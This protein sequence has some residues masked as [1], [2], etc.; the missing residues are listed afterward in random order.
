MHMAEGSLSSAIVNETIRF[1]TSSLDASGSIFCWFNDKSHQ[2][3]DYKVAGVRGDIMQKY[4]EGSYS[5]DPLNIYEIINKKRRVAFLHEERHRRTEYENSRHNDFMR[6]YNIRDEVNFIFCNDRRPF[7]L[8][9]VLKQD[10][11]PPFSAQTTRWD[12]MRDYLEFTLKMHPKVQQA[13]IQAMLEG[14]FNLTP[15]EIEV[16]DLLANGASNGEIAQLMGIGIATVKTHVI[17]ILNKLGVE[18]RSAVV[19]FMSR[20]PQ[21]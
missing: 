4:L 1:A 18:N 7:A 20:L 5:C 8:M 17:N 10:K 2:V 21:A 14:R 16:T 15:R 9:A 11:D 19:A 3:E 12:A 6:S 13:R